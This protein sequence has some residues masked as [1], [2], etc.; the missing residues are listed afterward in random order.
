MVSVDLWAKRVSRG[1]NLPVDRIVIHSTAPPGVPYP[2][3]SAAGQARSTAEYFASSSAGGSAHRVV[4]V[5]TSLVCVPDEAIAWHAPPNPRSV[6]IEICSQPSYTR[7]QWLSPTVWPAV[8]RAATAT[9]EIAARHNVP[10]RRIGPAELRAG[11]RGVTGHVDV[12]TTWRQSDHWD[13]GPNFPW[14]EFMTLLQPPVPGPTQEDSDMPVVVRDPATG[15]IAVLAGAA[16]YAL[17]TPEDVVAW[18][19]PV[20]AGGMGAAYLG[21][22]PAV[23]TTLPYRTR[24]SA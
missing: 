19:R 3:A 8:A 18:T 11:E 23:F 4:D 10:L 24:E 17:R 1:T 2:R 16:L 6:G 12:S 13:P 5:A 7:E 21:D 14:P 20:A 22:R 15:R 9:L